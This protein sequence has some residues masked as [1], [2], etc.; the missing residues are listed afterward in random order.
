MLAGGLATALAVSAGGEAGAA[1]RGKKTCANG[2]KLC[3]RK[4]IPKRKRCC[5]GAKKA[6]G[7]Q[8]IPKRQTCCSAAKKP[9]GNGCIPKR[10]CRTPADCG[11]LYLCVRGTCVIGQGVCLDGAN[12]CVS[13]SSGRCDTQNA[14]CSCFQTTAGATRC[15]DNRFMP[16]QVCVNDTQCAAWHPT[17]PGVFCARG[18]TGGGGGAGG[19]PVA[20]SFCHAPC[21]G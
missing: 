11:D 3:G 12:S 20:Q 13:G 4:C 7:K 18:G 8:C 2:K 9:C 6:C 10:A 1:K 15:G 5:P 16:S 19:C 17:I 14:F 21:P